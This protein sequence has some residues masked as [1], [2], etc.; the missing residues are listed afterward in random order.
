M[1]R[2]KRR[3]AEGIARRDPETAA[4][5]LHNQDLQIAALQ[6]R[7]RELEAERAALEALVLVFSNAE[8]AI[9]YDM[10]NAETGEITTVQK[11]I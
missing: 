3:K 8:I 4:R 2:L 9:R 5:L 6:R 7:V 1:S 11:W 10:V